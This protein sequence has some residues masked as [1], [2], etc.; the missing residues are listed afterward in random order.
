MLNFGFLVFDF[1]SKRE[2]GVQVCSLNLLHQYTNDTF[3]SPTLLHWFTGAE[4]TLKKT[5]G[6]FRLKA[7]RVKLQNTER[8]SNKRKKL[9]L[10]LNYLIWLSLNHKSNQFLLQTL[11]FL[12]SFFHLSKNL[13][14]F[15][16]FFFYCN[17][18][19]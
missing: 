2:G 4:I 12:L 11:C 7:K 15:L 19:Q 10:K 18:L 3:I 8:K 14:N 5:E 13:L 17:L 9:L 6:K 16:F 1:F